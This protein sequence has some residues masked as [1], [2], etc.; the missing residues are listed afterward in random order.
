VLKHSRINAISPL[1]A[2]RLTA[3]LI[4]LF[5]MGT[6]VWC[7]TN[8]SDKADKEAAKQAAKARNDAVKEASKAIKQG[9]FEQL[10]AILEANPDLV[11]KPVPQGALAAIATAPLAVAA[12]GGNGV[13]LAHDAAAGV[14]LLNNAAYYNRKDAAELLITYHAD[15]NAATGLGFTPLHE[16][17][18]TRSIDVVRVLLDHGADVNAKAK[19]GDTPLKLLRWDKANRTRNQP[20]KEFNDIEE[21][22]LQ[23]GAH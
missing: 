4:T 19:N 23:H 10:K 6:P 16:A 1:R 22:L 9:N 3:I 2:I 5:G 8:G 15:V 21:L 17:V 14:T 20:V 18:M 13:V 11:S 12:A 7:Q